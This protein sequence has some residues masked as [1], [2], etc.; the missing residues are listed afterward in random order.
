MNESQVH[1]KRICLSTKDQKKN[2]LQP[3]EVIF[4]F[5]PNTLDWLRMAPAYPVN[6]PRSIRMIP[7]V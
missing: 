3:E 7:V 1:N 5:P 4:F 6:L 2:H